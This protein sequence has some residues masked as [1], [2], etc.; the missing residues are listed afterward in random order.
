MDLRHQRQQKLLRQQQP[1]DK[2]FSES[3]LAKIKVEQ[4]RSRRRFRKR[5]KDYRQ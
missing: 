2:L 5:K 1:L 3:A 4:K